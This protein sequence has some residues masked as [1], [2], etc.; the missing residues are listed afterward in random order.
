MLSM[1]LMTGRG[2]SYI[3]RDNLEIVPC[4]RQLCV[5]V[6]LAWWLSLLSVIQSHELQ[7]TLASVRQRLCPELSCFII[8][9]LALQK[10]IFQFVNIFFS[11]QAFTYENSKAGHAA[12]FLQVEIKCN[13]MK[14]KIL[15]FGYL[16]KFF[17]AFFCP[18]LTITR[19]IFPLSQAGVPCFFSWRY[20]KKFLNTFIRE[21]ME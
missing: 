16:P 7:G 5:C 14:V 3:R 18:T 1:L 11:Y 6:S 2:V 19:P 12:Q 21:F 13:N 4:D 9:V 20:E 10:Y 8:F 17:M 15:A